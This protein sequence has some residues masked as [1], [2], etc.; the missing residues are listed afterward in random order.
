MRRSA[1]VV[2]ACSALAAGPRAAVAQ[3]GIDRLIGAIN[4]A[5]INTQAS[6][7][8]NNGVFRASRGGRCGL[9]GWGLEIALG[10]SP[11]SARTQYQLDLGYAQIAGFQSRNPNLD[12]RGVMRLQPEVSFY[13]TRTV[14]P[15]LFPYVGLHSGIVTLNDIQAYSQPGDTTASFSAS[16]LQLGATAG[17]AVRSVYFDVGYRYRDFH[18][19]HWNL[20]NNTTVLPAGWPKSAIMNA[21]QFTLGVSFGVEGI[22]HRVHD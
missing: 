8:T 1:L 15:W 6:C 16:T 12:L 9:Y 2:I 13:A 5:N 17:V 20:G 10:L 18:S 19:L 22:T 14:K 4:E 7:L 21:L 3:F 11:D